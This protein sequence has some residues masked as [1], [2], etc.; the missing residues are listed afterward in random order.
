MSRAVVACLLAVAAAACSH[1]GTYDL[2]W[3]FLAAPSASQSGDAGAD[4]GGATDA[5]GGP[6]G[7]P[8]DAASG[9]GRHGVF[10]IRVTG[11]S[12]EGNGEDV[13]ATCTSGH[14]SH[15]VASGTWDFTVHALDARGDLKQSDQTAAG[16]TMLNPTLSGVMIIDGSTVP[17][18]VTFVPQPECSDGVDNDRDGRVD[19]NDPDCAGDPG[20]NE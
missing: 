18:V 2:S 7:Q 19:L 13:M 20:G 10:S 17:V 14:F 5:G 12:V 6:D 1:E 8:E 15:K 16:P 9:C 11:S 4:D 3:T